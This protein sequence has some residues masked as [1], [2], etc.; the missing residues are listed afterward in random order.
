MVDEAC[1]L[2]KAMIDYGLSP[3]EVTRVTLA[4]DKRLW[5]RTFRTLLRKL[6]SEKKVGV[7]ALF[8]Q[9]LLEKDGSPDRVTLAAFTMACSESGGKNNLVT[10]LRERESP[11]E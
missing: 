6:C 10:D 8:Y 4:Y 1:K 2:Y 7:A 9:K 11:A 5:I 3:S